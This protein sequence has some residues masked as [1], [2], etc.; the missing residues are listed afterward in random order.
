MGYRIFYY[1]RREQQK[2][3]QEKPPP[4]VRYLITHGTSLMHARTQL[5]PSQRGLRWGKF[6]Q[7][8][9]RIRE[10]L[11]NSSNNKACT[12]QPAWP[13]LHRALF[14][15]QQIT[16]NNNTRPSHARPGR[17]DRQYTIPTSN[18][19]GPP[20]FPP[21]FQYTTPEAVL[22]TDLKLS[23]PAS[24]ADHPPAWASHTSNLVLPAPMESMPTP[25][26]VK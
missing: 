21:H 25:N 19:Q 2:K 5:H 13:V 22:P 23:A 7:Q 15:E 1:T 6:E 26:P 20:H 9:Q 14:L 12:S 3:G 18:P 16:V 10:I 4:Y 11:N 17:K 8:Q 24:R